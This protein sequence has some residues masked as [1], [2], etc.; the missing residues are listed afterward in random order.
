M[1]IKLF[2]DRINKTDYASL[3]DE[4]SEAIDN[5]TT[6]LTELLIGT[7][8]PDLYQAHGTYSSGQ[9]NRCVGLDNE[10]YTEKRLCKCMYYI[11]DNYPT[12]CYKCDFQ[13]RLKIIGDYGIIDYEVPAFYYGDGI[14]EID[15]I[16]S[17]GKTSYAT[18]VKPYKNNKETLLRMIAEIMTY[19]LGYPTGKYKK[20][21]AFFEKNREDNLKTCQQLEFEQVNSS[22]ITLL[23]KADVTVFRFEEDGDNRYRI[24]KL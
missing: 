4:L 1:K 23:K 7:R 21:I 12:S 15:L 11:N 6:D 10:S 9:H 22:I 17:D 20:A 18:E 8:T 5:G 2:K 14:G 16:I 3:I 13:E 24:C 19:T